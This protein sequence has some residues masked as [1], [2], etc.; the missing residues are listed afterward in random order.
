MVLRVPLALRVAQREDPFLGT[1]PLFV[2]PGA[3]E[4]RVES[5]R[6]QRVEQRLGLEQPAAAL[7]ADEE[8]LRAFRNRLLVGVH[9]EPRA[10]LGGVLIAEL[11]HLAELVRGVH[12]EERE[13]DGARVKG[14]LREPQEHGRI[15]PNRI[16]HDGTLEFGHHFTQDM[17]ALR[18][19]RS[20][21]VEARRG[22]RSPDERCAK[23]AR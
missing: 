10:D 14:L 11:D 15:L 23:K 7:R 19:E 17:D 8:G 9:D 3:A 22:G 21:V 1:R 18:L 12:V 5:A 2:A 20:Q 6:L 4:R 16:E 13:G